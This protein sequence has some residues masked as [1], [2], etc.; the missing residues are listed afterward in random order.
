MLS[1]LKKKKP[2]AA[3]SDRSDIRSRRWNYDL[4]EILAR[5]GYHD[6]QVLSISR[7]QDGLL[8]IDLPHEEGVSC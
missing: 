8:W 7:T 1:F 6:P 4:T 2:D 3:T 5:Q